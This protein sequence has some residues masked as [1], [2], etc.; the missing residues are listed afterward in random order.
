MTPQD[1]ELGQAE[2]IRLLDLGLPDIDG[3]LGAVVLVAL[4]VRYGMLRL[5]TRVMSIMVHQHNYIPPSTL[6]P[7]QHG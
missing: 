6:Y 1:P 2:L 3:R 7:Q 4:N 5:S